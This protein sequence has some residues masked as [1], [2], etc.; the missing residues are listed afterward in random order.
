MIDFPRDVL[1]F[2]KTFDECRHNF[3]N[4]NCYWFAFILKERFFQEI[5][6]VIMYHP[7]NN[8]FAC[9]MWYNDRHYILDV[10]GVVDVQTNR[11]GENGWESWFTYQCNEPLGAKRVRRDC[12]DHQSIF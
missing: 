9:G 10:T 4:G 12:I 11:R 7:V 2:I 3:L 8:H 1:N 5:P 6:C